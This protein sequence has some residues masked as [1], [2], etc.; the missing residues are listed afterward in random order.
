LNIIPGA[1]IDQTTH[2][3]LVETSATVDRKHTWFGRLD[4]VGKPAHDLHAHE[5]ITEVFTVGKL[6]AGYVRNLSP[7]KG[8]L[9]GVGVSVTASVVPAMLASRYRGRIAPGFGLFATIRPKPSAM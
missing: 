5:F 7:W 2:A 4:V 8:L 6:Q 3:V 9:P 1:L